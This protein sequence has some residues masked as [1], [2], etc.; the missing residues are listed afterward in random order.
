MAKRS[1]DSLEQS[2]GRAAQGQ[3]LLQ[4]SPLLHLPVHLQG[5]FPHGADARAR[6]GRGRGAARGPV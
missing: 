4:S 5:A 6:E 1:R 3:T 2:R